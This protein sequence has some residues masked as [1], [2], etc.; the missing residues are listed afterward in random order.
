MSAD[1]ITYLLWHDLVG[2]TRTRGVPTRDLQKRMA[3]GLGWARAGQALTAFTD[4]VDNPW[5]PMDEVRQ[6]PDPAAKF[7]IPGSGDE[8]DL[9]AVI[10]DSK[11]DEQTPWDCCGRSFLRAA[12]DDLKAEAGVT[13]FASFEHEF[14]LTGPDFRPA[15]P[16]S[17]TA[18]RQQNRFLTDLEAA[19]TATGVTTYTIEPEYGV[20]QYEVACAPETG[21]RAADACLIARETIREIARRHGLSASFTPKPAADAVG[22]GAHIHLSLVNAS[23]ENQTYD[24]NGP[25]NLSPVAAHFCAGVLAHIEALL[26]FTAPAPVSYFRLGPHHWSAGFRA[27]GLQNREAS[28]RIT[29]GLGAEESRRKGHNIEYRPCDGIASPYLALAVIVRAGLEGIRRKLACPPGITVDP[30]EMADAEREAA[31]VKALPTSLGESLEA[32]LSDDVARG[33]F[34]KDLLDTYVALKRWEINQASEIGAGQTFARY[35]TAY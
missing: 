2:V 12:L 33:W 22:N 30:A 7:T 27:I 17:M 6:V 5:G 32:L 20:G 31:G 8:P 23:G 3:N 34:S 21:V 15:T 29:P 11:V 4:I 18:A 28:L 25:M 24:A 16:F 13:I 14:L 9:H 1:G 19:L 10:C 35:L 26:A